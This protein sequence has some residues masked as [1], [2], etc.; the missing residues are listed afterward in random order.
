MSKYDSIK[1]LKETKARV[2]RRCDRCSGDI[3]RGTTYYKESVGKINTIGM[4]LKG[5]C[6]KC[7]SEFGASLLKS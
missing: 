1:F 3:V 2:S 7:H 6:V 4:T 5:F